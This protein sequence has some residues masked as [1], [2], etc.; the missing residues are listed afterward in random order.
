M[1]KQSVND[2]YLVDGNRYNDEIF[3]VYLL[4]N[5]LSNGVS[6]FVLAQNFVISICLSKSV[7]DHFSRRW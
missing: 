3:R 1:F 6:H 5:E 4:F 7:N 2:Q